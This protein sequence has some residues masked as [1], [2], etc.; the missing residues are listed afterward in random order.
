[1]S[2]TAEAH[3]HA[4]TDLPLPSAEPA[5]KATPG[6]E[7]EV[8]KL[9]RAV[10]T[11]QGSDLHL[12]AGLPGM[13]RLRGSIQRMNMPPLS[14]EQLERL[15]YPIL[16]PT[17]R[18]ILDKKG[19][20]DMAYVIGNDECRFRVNLFKQRGKLALVARRVNTSIPTFEGLG[21][22]ESI[23]KLCHYEQGMVILA[24][25]T[26]SGKSTTIA[27]ML[28][29]INAREALHILTIE[30]PIE[31]MFTDKMSV[32]NQREVGLDVSDWHTAL[33]HAVRQDPDI[34]LVGEMRDRDTF[35]A[36]I[37]AAE[38]GHVVFGTIHASSAASTISRILDLFPPDMHRA[39]RQSMAFNLKAVV[40][41]KLVP[42]IKPGSSR[43][44]TNEIMIVNPTIRELIIKE[45]D[46]K[47][48][49]A[50]RIGFLE[51]M[52]DFTESLRRL[53]EWN[54]VTKE[55]ALE[56]APNPEQLKMAIKGIKVAA[57]GIL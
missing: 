12:K 8:N 29:Y 42:S 10:M 19:G 6:R 22:P 26:G 9:F 38:T 43:L 57:P 35:E 30:D 27:S 51:G 55:V 20:V 7:P 44:P 18:D 40:A 3:G 11:H 13:M 46:K 31:F 4:S 14:N 52:L 53:V 48:P 1:M 33:K 2:S 47:L 39:V 45:E 49:D 50:I 54:H 24:G 25:V 28:D 16:S 37:H 34:I 36:G 56:F 23:E 32:V 41:Q 17:Q 5:L 21:L 15:L